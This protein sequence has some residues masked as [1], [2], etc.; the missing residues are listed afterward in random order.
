MDA[1]IKWTLQEMDGDEGIA[2]SI[3]QRINQVLTC[4]LGIR[5]GS[6]VGS[7]LQEELFSFFAVDLSNSLLTN[8]AISSPIF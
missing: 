4:G 5:S 3:D 8:R 2:W 7:P 1:S 6:L